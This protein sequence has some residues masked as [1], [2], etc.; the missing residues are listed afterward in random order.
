MIK[1]L[2]YKV[3]YDYNELRAASAEWKNHNDLVGG[4]A[5]DFKKVNEAGNEA[6]KNIK[7]GLDNASASTNKF[8][9]AVKSVGPQILAA[10]S[11]GAAVG[12]GKEIL[13]ITSR[14]QTLEAVLTNTLGSS[15]AAQKALNDIK[16]FAAVTPFSVEQLTDSYVKLANQGFTP[17]VNQLRQLGDIASSTGKGFDQLTEAILDA[18]SGEFERLK[19]FGIKTSK[20]GDLLKFTFKGVKT[21]VDNTSDSIQKYILGLGDLEGVSGSMA[22]ISGTLEGQIS[23]LGDAFDSLLNTI[24]SQQSSVFSGFI[25]GLSSFIQGLN[26]A[27]TTSEQLK[28]S[29]DLSLISK[30]YDENLRGV[31]SSLEHYKNTVGSSSKEIIAFYEQE[32]EASRKIAKENNDAY[33]DAILNESSRAEILE[34]TR[35]R[36]NTGLTISDAER[37]LKEAEN[38]KRRINLFVESDALL[39]KEIEKRIKEIEKKESDAADKQLEADKKALEKRRKLLEREYE[40]SKFDPQRAVPLDIEGATEAR[41]EIADELSRRFKDEVENNLS[42][43]VLGHQKW[44]KAKQDETDKAHKAEL[45][46]EERHQVDIE[47]VKAQAAQTIS[48]IG[49]VFFQM[50]SDERNARLQQIQQSLA[51]ELKLAGDNKQQQAV[52]NNKYAQQE[53]QLKRQ[54]AQ[55]DKEQAIFNILLNTAVGVTKALGSAGPPLNFVLAALV[56]ALGGAQLIAASSKPLPRFNKGT[57]SVPG[58][59]TGDDSVLAMLRPKEKVFTVETSAKYQPALDAIFDHKVPAELINSFVLDQKKFDK[60]GIINNKVDNTELTNEVKGLRR[61]I[62]NLPVS[63]INIDKNGLETY[64]TTSNTK[65]V[66]MNNYFEM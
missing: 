49:N 16:N 32:L 31:E 58:I 20:H 3:G 18:Q 7:T 46:A 2:K 1:Y 10:F 11:I 30:K 48:G 63:H 33:G 65:T 66:K 28:S 50:E 53:R 51:T 25:G 59:D 19:E 39:I 42:A 56:A 38:E 45:E 47:K 54:Q 4:S 14:F 60:I 34:Q 26:V 12:L 55:A 27:L 23:N 35:K 37:L 62:Q 17:T 15:S 41:K 24:G 22:A 29:I 9:G 52:I 61:D 36:V 5:N 13:N 40:K 6:T 64:V 21:E 8:S 57:K 44:L 43:R